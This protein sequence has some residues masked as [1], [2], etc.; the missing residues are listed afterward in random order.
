M[1]ETFWKDENTRWRAD[2]VGF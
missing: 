1:M 2:T